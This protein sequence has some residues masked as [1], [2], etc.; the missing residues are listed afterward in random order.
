MDTHIAGLTSTHIAGL[1]STHIA[2][3]TSTHI[4][5]LTSTHIA[6][7]TSTNIAGLTSTNIAGLRDTHIAG[8]FI[9]YFYIILKRLL[10]SSNATSYNETANIA[11]VKH[12]A[13]IL[14]NC[15][16]SYRKVVT[17][18][19]KASCKKKLANSWIH[20]TLIQ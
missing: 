2:G 6:G 10:M 17:V 11:Y 13:T 7:L 5:G 3:L 14:T 16:D 8:Y 1:T 9:S 18:A 12:A 15:Q 20:L 4:A 19:D